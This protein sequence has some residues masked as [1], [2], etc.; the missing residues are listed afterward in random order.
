MTSTFDYDYD[1][2]FGKENELNVLPLITDFFN[3]DIKQTTDKYC[4][5]DFYDEK[6]KYEVKSR[7]NEHNTFETTLISFDKMD[8]NTILLFNFTDGLYYIEYNKKQ[9]EKY[10]KKYFQ[11]VRPGHTDINKL[12]IYIPNNELKLITEY[13]TEL[14]F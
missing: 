11:R 7:R 9:F 6:Y 5:Y 2:K 14:D 3:R 1:Y 13:C 4:K 12:C 8:K 10:E